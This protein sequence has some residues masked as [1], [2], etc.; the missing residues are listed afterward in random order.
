MKAARRLQASRSGA[1]IR[2]SV[3]EDVSGTVA[4]AASPNQFLDH[5]RE[6]WITAEK[7]FNRSRMP[8][9]IGLSLV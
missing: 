4:K 5:G 9:L 3:N 8:W 2:A 1:A 6:S 7:P